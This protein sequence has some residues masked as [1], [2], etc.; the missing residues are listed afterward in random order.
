MTEPSEEVLGLAARRAEARSSRDYGTADALRDQISA[1][2]WVVVDEAGGWRLEPVA[3]SPPRS[4]AADDVPSILGDPPSADASVHLVCEGWP[5]DIAR[6]IASIRAHVG[7]ADVRFVVADVAG[8]DPTAF[9]PDVEVLSLAPGTGW[10]SACNA[11]LRRA[12]GRIVIAMDGSVEARG[13]IVGP[14]AAT[15]ADARVGLAGPYGIATHD[16]RRF[17]EV[18][19]PGPCDAV[20]GYLMALRHE[21]LVTAGTFDPKFRWYRTADVDF[22]FRV[23]DLGLSTVVVDLPVVRHEHRMWEAT[24]PAERERLSKRNFYR[25]LEHWR[26]RWDLVL[27]PRPPEAD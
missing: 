4:I 8:E 3:S 21:T 20:E 17:D 13:D 19:G 25:F 1:A 16:L 24:D 7:S 12:C 15:L 26:G 22:S 11:G 18:S 27:D 23:K 9:G 10:A 14:L 6:A 2:G 5:G